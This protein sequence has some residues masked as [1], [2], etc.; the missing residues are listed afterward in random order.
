MEDGTRRAKIFGNIPKTY[1][2]ASKLKGLK[3]YT[4]VANPSKNLDSEWF[5]NIYLED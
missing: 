2:V 3:I 5:K 1:E 4:D